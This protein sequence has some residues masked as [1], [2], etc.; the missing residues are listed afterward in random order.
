[1]NATSIDYPCVLFIGDVAD[2]IGAKTAYAI[3][4]WRPE[5]C[6]GQIRLA[7]C[8]AD[9]GLKDLTIEEA[10]AA[11]ARTLIV[12]TV[13]VGGTLPEHWHATILAALAAGLD[14]ACGLHARLTE[15]P[16]VRAAAERH[17]R[18]L[19]D[20]RH[21]ARTFGCGTGEKRS[22]KRLLTVGTDCSSGKM[23]TALWIHKEMRARGL[24]ADFRATGQT[25]ILVSG[26]GICVDAVIS[27]FTSGATEW[28]SPANEPDHWDIIEGQGSLFH[29][30]ASG[31]TLGLIHGAQP[32]A[33]VM[34]HVPTRTR[35]R[36]LPQ[37]PLPRLRECLELN[38]ATARLT[39]PGVRCVGFS[40]N[41]SAM[42]SEATTAYLREVEREFELP[43]VDPVKMGVARIVDAL[44]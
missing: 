1:M 26:S 28:L 39:N 6:V 41:T 30:S 2:Q 34:C 22:G 16:A 31:V 44:V 24:R 35:M 25:G 43:C 10:V 37:Q 5:R 27:D 17:G 7:G 3:A 40:V 8:R 18:R 9:L 32:D 21:Q 12:G 42:T 33:I 36:G 15:I 38:L 29:P 19:F 13:N 23:F 14:V 20:V 4:Y 11:G